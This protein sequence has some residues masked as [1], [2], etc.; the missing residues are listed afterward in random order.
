MSTQ[1]FLGVNLTC[2]C[3]YYS[4]FKFDLPKIS[5]PI[6]DLKTTVGTLSLNAVA[7]N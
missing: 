5:M 3:H 4:L 7:T 6:A 2:K 1:V